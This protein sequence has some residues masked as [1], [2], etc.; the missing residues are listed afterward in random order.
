[1]STDPGVGHSRDALTIAR[2]TASARRE[3]LDEEADAI[4]DDFAIRLTPT[5]VDV[6]L[7]GMMQGLTND[8]IAT[9]V[10]VRRSTVATHVH[11]I[12]QALR[13]SSRGEAVYR[14]QILGLVG[15]GRRSEALSQLRA[16]LRPS[17]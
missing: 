2:W 14:A 8:Q 16:R 12:I 7:P 15:I 5:Q 10:G 13:A 9:E 6:I 17:R 4:M 1:M 11:W 3:R